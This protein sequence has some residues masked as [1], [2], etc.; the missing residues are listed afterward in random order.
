MIA[1]TKNSIP[2][3][4]LSP[5]ICNKETIPNFNLLMNEIS[6]IFKNR[7]IKEDFVSIFCVAYD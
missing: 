1:E 2:K 6:I 4:N 5:P 3:E 7:L